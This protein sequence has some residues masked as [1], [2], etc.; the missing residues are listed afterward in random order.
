MKLVGGRG[1]WGGTQL[2]EKCEQ[3]LWLLLAIGASVL[4]VACANL[5]NLLVARA[6][7]R[8]REIAVREALGAS[9]GRLVRQ[10]LVESLLLAVAGA[11]LGAGLAQALSR[12]LVAFLST[13][14]DPVFLEL[15][16]DWRVLGFAV[17]LAAV[18]CLLFGLAPAIRVT[19]M[20]P[21][22]AMKTGRRGVPARRPGP[23]SR[24]SPPAA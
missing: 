8:A 5:A 19:R 15:A 4:L 1:G 17:G 6:S 18:T 2:R 20:E 9:R 24:L 16:L 11:A 12:F 23:P 21:G 10:L 7:A 13:T 14:A 3:S 22:A